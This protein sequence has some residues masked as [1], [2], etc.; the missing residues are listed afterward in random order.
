VQR[1][2]LLGEEAEEEEEEV[3]FHARAT[4]STNKS[5]LDVNDALG[6]IFHG[7][8]PFDSSATIPP[9]LLP[10]LLLLLLRLPSP[11]P[12]PPEFA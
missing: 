3:L 1:F 5:I 2:F 10:L 11:H 6:V 12:H 8:G 4:P 9:L 7:W